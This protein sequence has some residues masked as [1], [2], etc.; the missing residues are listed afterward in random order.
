MTGQLHLQI[1]T[2]EGVQ[3]AQAVD[4]LTAPSVE[5]QFGVLPGHRSMVA[6]LSTGIVSYW[7]DGEQHQVAVGTGYVHIDSDRASI[8]TDRFQDKAAVDAVRTRLALQKAD[9]ALEQFDGDVGS[10]AHS[11]LVHEHLWSA[12]LLELY[13]DPPPPL[14]RAFPESPPPEDFVTRVANE[15]E[16]G[17]TA[18]T[19]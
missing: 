8:V 15:S 5:G 14:L 13:G 12:A 2:P 6:A 3:L 1:T 17:N 4:E 7:L 19:P 9:E 10:T 11:D 18:K 16:A